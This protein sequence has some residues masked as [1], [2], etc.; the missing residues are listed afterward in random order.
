M[1]IENVLLVDYNE[2]RFRKMG[3]NFGWKQKLLDAT[4]RNM[5]I[6]ESQGRPRRECAWP[7]PSQPL[8]NLPPT[9]PTH[10]CFSWKIQRPEYHPLAL[11]ASELHPA[12][13]RR[14]PRLS[15]PVPTQWCTVKIPASWLKVSPCLRKFLLWFGEWIYGTEEIK[16]SFCCESLWRCS[17]FTVCSWMSK[18]PLILSLTL[19]WSPLARCP[20]PNTH[21]PW[22]SP[23][24]RALL[25]TLISDA[26]Q[27]G[28]KVNAS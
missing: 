3:W 28:V 13:P 7:P 5:Q 24:K 26:Q 2:L 21:S 15:A 18:P 4:W 25:Q 27:A 9:N 14:P 23:W 1:G 22:W 19:M 12:S 8:Y 6:M 10:L 20:T 17:L 11:Q 16:S